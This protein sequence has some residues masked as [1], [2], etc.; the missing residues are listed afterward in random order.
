MRRAREDLEDMMGSVVSEITVGVTPVTAV[1]RPMAACLST[2]RREFPN[3]RLRVQE[4]RP[5]QLLEHLREGTM[6]FAVTS[7]LLPADRRIGLHPGLPPADH[8]CRAAR[9]SAA[10]G[11]VGARAAAG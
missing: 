5:T 8:H 11:P 10:R 6:D 7:Q 3:A 1:M 2:F 4:M 9:A